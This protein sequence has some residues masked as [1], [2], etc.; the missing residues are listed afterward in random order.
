MEKIVGDGKVIIGG[1]SSA[2]PVFKISNSANVSFNNLKFADISNGEIING[3]AAG[4]VEISGC[5]F[6]SNNQKGILVN[7]ANLLISDSKFENNNVFKCIYTN[8][9]EMRNCEFV[10]NTA[11]EKKSTSEV[12]NLIYLD[13]KDQ[14]GIIS[15][16]FF[17]NNN[18]YQGCI[19]VKSSDFNQGFGDCELRVFMNSTGVFRGGRLYADSS[20][21]SNYPIT[22]SSS[23]F[24]DNFAQSGSVAFVMK[25][26]Y[27]QLQIQSF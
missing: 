19:F 3:L 13:L 20:S 4:E 24:I 21:S 1:I 15:G 2:D 12:G 6:Y 22:I 16:T 26:V 7:V 27:L 11:N 25:N 17:E 14:Q 10:N 18:V 23:V 9:L 8:Y 5:E